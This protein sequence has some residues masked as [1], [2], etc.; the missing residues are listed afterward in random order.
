MIFYKKSAKW[1]LYKIHLKFLNNIF[2]FLETIL[3]NLN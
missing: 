2:V 1:E 3:I